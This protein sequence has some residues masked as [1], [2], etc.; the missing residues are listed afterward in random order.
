[1][2][3]SRKVEFPRSDWGDVGI[4]LPA[5]PQSSTSVIIGARALRMSQYWCT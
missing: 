1:M 3:E 4:D 2:P 5:E